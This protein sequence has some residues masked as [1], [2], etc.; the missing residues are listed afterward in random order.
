[1][2]WNPVPAVFHYE[3][4]LIFPAVEARVYDFGVDGIFV[5]RPQFAAQQVGRR[6]EPVEDEEQLREQQIEAVAAPDVLQFVFHDELVGG[7][8]RRHDQKP[9]QLKGAT[10]SRATTSV[11]SPIRRLSPRQMMQAM[12]P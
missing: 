7:I 3:Q 5:E 1:M 2:D 8:L 9:P 4:H 10:F 6:V 12:R 11:A